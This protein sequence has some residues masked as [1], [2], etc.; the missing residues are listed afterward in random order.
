VSADL[1][2]P[3]AGRG[4]YNSTTGVAKVQGLPVN[5]LTLSALIAAFPQS[6]LS[7]PSTGST[8]ISQALGVGFE[9][10]VGRVM[11][12]RSKF[13]L[14]SAGIGTVWEIQALLNGSNLGAVTLI[15]ATIGS[16][17][18]ADVELS[19]QTLSTDNGSNTGA[20]F[21]RGRV[22]YADVTTGTV[23][24]VLFGNTFTGRS[25]TGATTFGVA[26]FPNSTATAL[27][28]GG[29]LSILG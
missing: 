23:T 10:T 27:L 9:N 1:V 2:S 11:E 19:F 15:P 20:L 25:L 13:I 18:F 29:H 12:H 24:T 16:S 4:W 8:M 17:T 3:N 26:V 21:S 5:A 6:T 22:Q 28:L 7:V 14:A